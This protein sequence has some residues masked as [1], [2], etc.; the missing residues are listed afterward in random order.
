MRKQLLV[1]IGMVV[2]FAVTT[3]ITV[4]EWLHP[5]VSYPEARAGV[6]DARHWDF[7][8]QGIIPLRGEW[9]YYK[10][11]LLA[12][13]D[14]AERE[15]ELQGHRRMLNVPEDRQGNV[16]D[17]GF[18][19]GTYR[20]KVEVNEAESYSLRAKKIRLSSR[21]YM[22]GHDLGGTGRP[23]VSADRF[24]PS[25]LPFFGTVRVESD[26]VEIIIQVAS[27]RYLQGG[28]VQVPE[29]G[30][31][32]KVMNRRDTARMADMIVITTLLVFGIYFAGMFRQWRREP[33][34]I[35][36]SLF[37]LS[38]GLFFG[39]DD[40]I[41]FASL[42]PSISFP[43]LQKLLFILPS[44]SILF[45]IHYLLLY[46]DDKPGK[47]IKAFLRICYMFMIVLLFIPN[48]GLVPI[49]VPGILMQ[50]LAFGII[51]AS[52]FRNRHHGV[53]IYYVLLGAFFLVISWV[54]AQ[55]RYQLALD[56]PYFIIV[57]LLLVV[58]SQSFL[59]TDRIRTAYLRIERQAQQL[60]IYDRQKDEFL[61]KTSHE[62]RTPLHGIV[63]LSQSLLDNTDTPLA[64]EHRDNIRLLNLIGRRLAGLVNDILDLNRIRYGELRVQPKPVD[65]YISTAFVIETLSIAPIKSGVRL[66]NELPPTLPLVLADENRLRQILHNLLE[67]GLKYTDHGTVSI[68]AERQGEMLFIT[69]SDTGRGIPQESMS[70]LFQPFYQYDEEG[71]R[72]RDGIGLGLS[73]SK[74]LVE[75]Q[76][77]VMHVESEVGRGSRFTFT[78]PMVVDAAFEAAASTVYEVDSVHA[79][80]TEFREH[81]VLLS[82]AGAGSEGG[83]A[84][85]HILIV[86]DEPSN[87]KVAMDAVASMKHTYTAVGSGEE[88]LNA[89]RSHKPDLVL[90]DLMM[91]GISG[92]DICRDIRE[93]HGLSELPVLMLTASGQ[94]GDILAAF[95]AG[96]ND[97]LQKPFELAELKARVQSLLAMKNSSEQAVRREMDFLQTQITPHFLYNSLNALVGLSYKDVDKLRETIQHLTTYLRAKF[98]FVFQGQAVPLEREMELVHAYL[99]I[100]QLRFGQRLQV[101]YTIDERVHSL[102]PPLT[103]QP[104]VENAVRHGIGPKPEGGTVDIIVRKGASGVEIVVEDDGVGMNGDKLAQLEEGYSGGIGIGNVNRRLQM[105]YGRKLKMVSSPGKGT[106]ITIY[107]TEEHHVESHSD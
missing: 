8:K 31:T 54:F 13:R 63:N 79:E 55:T 35:F 14:F 65:V 91:P 107:L 75:L 82:T 29:F 85:S 84:T 16:S 72:S 73:I 98:T 102:L 44:L 9:E 64:L 101:R 57:T 71:A 99:A 68:S 103:L 60:M 104:I 86:D 39:I 93:L 61:A 59:M 69:V 78:L 41:V 81:P 6:L 83:E 20:L 4:Y 94:T 96:A 67:N 56:S 34:L 15:Q 18:G 7:A 80:F 5:D 33:Y 40:E 66:V 90:L 36:F 10:D 105:R 27:F 22:A 26:T 58:L 70:H 53:K 32:D 3:S 25:N 38:L 19:A 48:E 88:A 50:I 1:L 106:R 52:I 23:D 92:L 62:L 37:C 77:G 95:T 43:L 46:L 28:L 47:W 51:F 42:M 49:L 24:V 21:I 17:S 89:L 11:Q 74:Q 12:P 97:I 76:G 30:A 100:E 45:F 87:L 2:V